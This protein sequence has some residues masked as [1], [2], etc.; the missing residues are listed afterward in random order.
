MWSS[1]GKDLQ[2]GVPWEPLS[3]EDAKHLAH[4]F[5]RLKAK[6]TP[7]DEEE[8]WDEQ[9]QL[10]YERL[11]RLESNDKK[12]AKSLIKRYGV[13]SDPPDVLAAMVLILTE[14]FFGEQTPIA[15]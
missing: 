6:A 10:V 3:E 11:P 1:E 9:L 12:T 13:R 8:S 15:V 2:V 7:L 14:A 5:Q 4:I